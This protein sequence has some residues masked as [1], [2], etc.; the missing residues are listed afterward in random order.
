MT[1]SLQDLKL[2]VPCLREVILGLQALDSGFNQPTAIVPVTKETVELDK[3]LAKALNQPEVDYGMLES[4]YIPAELVIEFIIH[5]I[6]NGTMPVESIE[7]RL[8]KILTEI[9][10]LQGEI[11]D[12]FK[13]AKRPIATICSKQGESDCEGFSCTCNCFNQ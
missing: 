1:V 2:F 3:T 10:I 5:I 9:T 8:Q 7:E 13:L 6:E 4:L 12:G 11:F